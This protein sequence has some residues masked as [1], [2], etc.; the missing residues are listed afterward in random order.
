M[1]SK[2]SKFLSEISNA[3]MTSN[4]LLI[5]ACKNNGTNSL[6]VECNDSTPL[7]LKFGTGY[8]PEP[9]R[10]IFYLMGPILMLSFSFSSLFPKRP[11]SKSIPQ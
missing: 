9:L 11:F 10:S 7:T 5:Y 8:N 3:H 2:Y 6:V 4:R 1:G